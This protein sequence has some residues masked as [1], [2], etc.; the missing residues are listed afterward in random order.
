MDFTINSSD[1]RAQRSKPSP[2]TRTH[3]DAGTNNVYNVT[4]EVKDTDGSAVDDSIDVV[5]TITN[6]D[7]AGTVTLPGTITAGQA[8]T[9]T[10]TDHDGTTQQ[11]NRGSGRYP[12]RQLRDVHTHQRGHLPTLTRP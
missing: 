12:T 4:V 1:G 3:R 11:R 9:A 2:T 7:E 5:V 8:A 6:I 10:L